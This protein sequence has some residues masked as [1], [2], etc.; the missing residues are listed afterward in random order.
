MFALS[1]AP[2][3]H[4][5]SYDRAVD[6]G[7]WIDQNGCQDTRAALLIRTSRA[8]VTFTDAAHCT[9]R[10][11]RW[12]DPWSGITT[13]VAHELQID[14][15]VPLENAWVSGAWSWTAEQR[16]AYANDV[17]DKDHLVVIE[18]SENESKGSGGPDDWRPPKRS[19]WC[20]Y[21][22][23]WDRGKVKWHLSV[24]QSEWAALAEMATTC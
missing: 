12:T 23:A 9:V 11:G 20:R 7:G 24:T 14:H 13:T 22:R 2:Q 4:E 10:S 3:S 5:A 18:A 21:A 15:T 19:M 8:L 17:A 16:V 1:I 6:F